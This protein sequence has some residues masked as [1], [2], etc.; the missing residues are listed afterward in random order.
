[1]AAVGALVALVS[2][3]KGREES[4]TTINHNS[5]QSLTKYFGL[6][7]HSVLQVNQLISPA[8]HHPV[9]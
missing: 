3:E 8:L 1:M 4:I 9:K 5:Q 7:L 6:G 2:G